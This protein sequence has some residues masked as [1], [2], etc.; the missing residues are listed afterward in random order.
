MPSK[1]QITPLFL[2]IFLMLFFGRINNVNANILSFVDTSKTEQLV[3]LS[4]NQ[5]SLHF[6]AG[7]LSQPSRVAFWIDQTILTTEKQLSPIYAWQILDADIVDKV[8]LEIPFDF[9]ANDWQ[10]VYSPDGENFLPTTYEI[11]K[12]SVIIPLPAK[13]GKIYITS[14]VLSEVKINLDNAT[15]KK[16]YPVKTPDGFFNFY[17]LPDALQQSAEITIKPLN[18]AGFNIN[19]GL[20]LISPIYYFYIDAADG[21][22]PQK[23][24]PIDIKYFGDNVNV[25]DI[26]YWD[27]INMTWLPSP[28]I[29]RYNEG[30][31]RTLTHQR[32][33][34]LAVFSKEIMEKGI[35]SW[36]RYKGGDFAASPDY[37]KGTKLKVTNL[38][39]HKSVIVAVNDYGPDR[40]VHPERIID[41]D[42]VAF[43][44]IADPSAGVIVVSVEENYY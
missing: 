14:L 30:V 31:V 42:R 26:Y 1:K 17:I 12:Q 24:L 27:N 11:N 5:A 4:E 23:D 38:A 28:S 3:S 2:T 20:K 43:A 7:S 35:A 9:V 40:S 34:I 39:N 19:P 18:L 8:F 36:Y 33:M 10:V 6:F 21:E 32:E 25:K 37:A 22:F 44:K 16:G 41:L 15:V 29:T 13:N